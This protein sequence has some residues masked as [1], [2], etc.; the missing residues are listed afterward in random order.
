MSA[1]NKTTKRPACA[2]LIWRHGAC[3]LAS[4]L[5]VL[6]IDRPLQPLS[7]HA[8]EEGR[9]HV[10]R[11]TATPQKVATTPDVSRAMREIRTIVRNNHSLVTHRRLGVA[12]AQSMAKLVKIQTAAIRASKPSAKLIAAL[13]PLLQDIDEGVAAIAAPTEKL[14]R[15]DG[16]FQIDK[17]L[18]DYGTRITDPEWKSLRAQ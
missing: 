3:A 9:D 14:S 2:A 16:L 12:Q 5:M 18:A 6:A 4:A 8:G 10:Q 11:N 1:L 15:I 17:A 7:A 13:A